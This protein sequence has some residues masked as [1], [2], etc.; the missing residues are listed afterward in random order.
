MLRGPLRRSLGEPDQHDPDE[1]DHALAILETHLA[2]GDARVDD[3]DEEL[4][5]RRVGASES[6]RDLGEATHVVAHRANEERKRRV[7]DVHPVRCFEQPFELA[8]ERVGRRN[9]LDE[10]AVDPSLH[11]V[12]HGD[13]QVELGFDVVVQR[14]RRDPRRSCELLVRHAAVAALG[15]ESSS[16]VDDRSARV[17]RVGCRWPPPPSCPRS[18]STI[19]RV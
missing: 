6:V 2:R 3:G 15:E 19:P 11:V 4:V 7:V 10:P 12:V 16:V 17:G 1:L 5:A 18:L 13:I 9:C 8:E 14:S